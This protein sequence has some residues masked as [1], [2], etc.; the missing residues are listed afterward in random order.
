MNDHSL[1]II[2]EEIQENGLD[3]FHFHRY[4]PTPYD[5]LETLFKAYPLTTDDVLVD[6]GCGL[7]RACFL[8]SHLFNC[9]SVGIEFSEEYYDRALENLETYSGNSELVSFVLSKAEDYFIEA[10]QNYFYLFNPFSLV[11]FKKVM[12]QI[13]ASLAVAERKVTMV[14]YYP[15]DDVIFYIE[16][17]TLF[18][19]VDE[20][21]ASD[22]IRNDR[23]ER[24]S[25]YEYTPF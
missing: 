8:A 7:G 17:H 6:F 22:E 2:T 11:I 25:I 9:R 19:R 1:Q 18:H 24:F 12:N 14:L 21:A 13:L 16:N 4:E 5:V 10:D 20:L 3:T 15:E 23:R